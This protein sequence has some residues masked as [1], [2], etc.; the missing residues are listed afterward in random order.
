MN[1]LKTLKISIWSLFL[2]FSIVFS[3]A[4]PS[5]GFDKKIGEHCWVGVDTGVFIRQLATRIETPK[6]ETFYNLNGSVTLVTGEKRPTY[7]TALYDP[8]IQKIK[9]VYT[10]VGS[11]FLFGTV[12]IELEPTTLDGTKNLIANNGFVH[13]EDVMNTPCD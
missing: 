2:C 13:T 6:S 9:V 10:Y 3:F 1:Q 5:Y 11:N 4:I 8:T 12:S 7:G